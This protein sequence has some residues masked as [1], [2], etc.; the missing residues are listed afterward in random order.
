MGTHRK[1]L[2]HRPARK[3]EATVIRRDAATGRFTSAPA[4]EPLPTYV[5]ETVAR[6][7]S[8]ADQPAS[9]EPMSGEDYLRWLNG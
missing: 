1:P 4:G 6:I 8:L 9:A 7:K 3:T 5:P 2:E